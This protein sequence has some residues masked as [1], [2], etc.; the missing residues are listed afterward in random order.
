MCTFHLPLM[1]TRKTSELKIV[2]LKAS[3][4]CFLVLRD[5]DLSCFSYATKY[6]FSIRDASYKL[7]CF[8][9]APPLRT[10][11]SDSVCKTLPKSNYQI[12]NTMK[13]IFISISKP[14]KSRKTLLLLLYFMIFGGSCFIFCVCKINGKTNRHSMRVFF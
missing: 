8:V 11:S 14:N 3:I 10:G 1:C 12:C 13:H 5:F 7:L 2:S 4:S 6:V 9:Q